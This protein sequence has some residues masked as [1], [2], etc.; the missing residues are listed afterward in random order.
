MTIKEIADTA[1]CGVNTVKRWVSE[2]MPTK[3]E[4]GKV[5]RFTW[6]EAHKVMDAMPKRNNVAQM[7]QVPS[8]IGTGDRIDRLEAMVEKLVSAFLAMSVQNQ[9]VQRMALEAPQIKPR[10]NI[11][12]IVREYA[13]RNGIDHRTA[14]GD[15][16]REFGYRTNSD[17]KK[18][19]KNRGMSVIDY[20]EAEGMIETLEAI[21]IEWAK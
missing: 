17:P 7:V 12:K 14:W 6:E 11:N 2:N 3:M 15:L 20:I 10:D 5:T 1:G 13:N 18:C 16:Y 21:A 9:P 19:A 8:P 4:K